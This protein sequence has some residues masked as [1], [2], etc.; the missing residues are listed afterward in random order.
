MNS[1][2]RNV[3]KPQPLPLLHRMEERAGERRRVSNFCF[4]RMPLSSILSPLVPR[5]ERKKN[6]PPKSLSKLLKHSS[7]QYGFLPDEHRSPGGWAPLPLRLVL[8]RTAIHKLKT[9][10]LVATEKTCC[11][12]AGCA[13]SFS[14]RSP[15]KSMYY[16]L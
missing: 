10:M 15:R 1:N 16:Y 13:A 7:L 3:A 11:Q 6:L 12:P 4:L 5:G 8:I 2:E 14:R 9:N